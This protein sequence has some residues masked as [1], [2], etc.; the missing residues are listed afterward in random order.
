MLA[1]Y[2]P[3]VARVFAAEAIRLVEHYNFRAAVSK[4]TAVKPLMLTACGGQPKWWQPHYN[5]ND[6]RN[7]QR[8]L[9]ADGP[10]S[11]SSIPSGVS[12]PA[13]TSPAPTTTAT[14][15]A[16][17]K[18]PAKAATKAPAKTVAKSN[19]VAKAKAP[20]RGKAKPKAKPPKK[21]VKPAKKK[22]AVKKRAPAKKSTR[23]TAKPKSKTAAKSKA[24]GDESREEDYPPQIAR[25]KVDEFCGRAFPSDR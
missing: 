18:T 15:P 25:T 9:F 4:A 8:L 3:V 24:S 10:S 20:T 11:V 23:A 14:V 17:K 6:M 22:T 19:P 21:A 2:D 12:V 1:F 7:V 13:V 16:A 5:A